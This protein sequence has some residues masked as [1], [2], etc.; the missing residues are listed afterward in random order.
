M[1]LT[2]PAP[3]ARPVVGFERYHVT[4]GGDVVGPSG[5]VL[6]PRAHGRTGHLRV[7]LYGPGAPVRPDGHGG[8]ARYVDRYVHRLVCE[9]FHG[10]GWEEAVVLH[11]DDDPA[12]N[13]AAN[14]AWGSPRQNERMRDDPER[15]ASRDGARNGP[16][17][18]CR[19]H[20]G[21]HGEVA[22]EVETR[23][24]LASP[25]P[26]DPAAG[27]EGVPEDERGPF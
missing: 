16:R 11:L 24:G 1:A 13:T 5:R 17:E 27:W 4:Q 19:G 3:G 9:A 22:H 18:E 2:R 26:Y 23:R 10:P 15:W 14:L 20:G 25:P 21:P 6:R 12:N 8:R 7:R